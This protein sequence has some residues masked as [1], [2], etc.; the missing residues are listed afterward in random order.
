MTQRQID[1][2]IEEYRASVTPAAVQRAVRYQRKIGSPMTAAEV[3]QMAFAAL[4]TQLNKGA[5]A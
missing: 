5:V 3:R 1:T 2:A 4:R